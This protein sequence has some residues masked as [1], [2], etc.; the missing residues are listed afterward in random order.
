MRLRIQ[1]PPTLRGGRAKEG[2]VVS[3]GEIHWAESEGYKQHGFSAEVNK[4]RSALACTRLLLRL[5]T[6]RCRIGHVAA[7]QARVRSLEV[8]L[9]AEALPT[10][11][12]NTQ[13]KQACG[14]SHGR[15]HS[16]RVRKGARGRIYAGQLIKLLARA[17]RCCR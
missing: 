12:Q 11:S 14:S 4:H 8:S 16:F 6:T 17:R 1:G 7:R 10:S 3:E 15:A 13:A 2:G 9:L 5:V